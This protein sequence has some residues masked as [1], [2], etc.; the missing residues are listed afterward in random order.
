[1]DVYKPKRRL[2]NG[3]N[4]KDQYHLKSIAGRQSQIVLPKHDNDFN[5]IDKEEN[6]A[7]IYEA[8]VYEGSE[9]Q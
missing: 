5:Y 9:K 2:R 3:T 7:A 6:G 4:I 8:T 1:M